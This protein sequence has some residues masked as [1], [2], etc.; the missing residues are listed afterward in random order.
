MNV[1]LCLP[2]IGVPSRAH[3]NALLRLVRKRPD[4]RPL[5]LGFPCIDIARASLTREALDFNADVLVFIDSDIVFEVAD[6][7]A[8]VQAAWER[9]CVVGAVYARKV[10]GGAPVV[11]WDGRE[12]TFYEGGGLEPV[13][14]LGLGFVAVHRKVFERIELKEQVCHA[15]NPPRRLRPY[16]TGDPAW[17]EMLLDDGAFMKRVRDSGSQIL[18]DTR[19]RIGHEGPKVYLLEDAA[20][21]P[22]RRT[23]KVKARKPPG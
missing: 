13:I 4:W 3:D 16:F 22:E 5:R 12:L 20:P 19:L 1:F 7:D 14:S 2:S 10:D 17:D 11:A 8:I 18:A 23:L 15:F 21:R 9:E 6:V